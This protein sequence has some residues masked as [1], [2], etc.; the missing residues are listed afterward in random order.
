[1][2]SVQNHIHQAIQEDNSL[3]DPN[4]CR[5][6]VD[7]LA[8]DLKRNFPDAQI[9]ILAYP[10]VKPDEAGVHYA[11]SVKTNNEEILVNPV[12]TG[13]FP[14]YIGPKS[15]A[16]PTFSMMKETELSETV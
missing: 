14:Q 13:L 11:L 9:V 2:E 5:D 15:L 16:V 6:S 10:D 1:M 12:A 3:E 4:K 8:S 7:K